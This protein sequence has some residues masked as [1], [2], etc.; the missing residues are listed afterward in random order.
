MNEIWGIILAAGESKRMGF[1][2]MLLKFNGITMIETVIQN[3]IN[4]DIDNTIVVLGANSQTLTELL[5]KSNVKY[6]FNNN[7]K[8]GMLSSVKCGF[9]NLPSDLKAVLVFLGDQP[10]ITSNVINKVIDAHKFSGKGI[11]IPIY[12]KKRGHPILIDKKYTEAIHKLDVET[13][14]RSL[15]YLFADDVLEVDTDDS[16]ILRDFDTYE[17]YIEEINQNK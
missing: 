9:K 10:F 4:A 11:V 13:G 1:P 7:Y 6:C 2:K 5:T 17:D 12:Q 14:L 8:E 3:V 15:T 16:G